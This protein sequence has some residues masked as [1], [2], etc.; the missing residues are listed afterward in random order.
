MWHSWVVI[1]EC[2]KKQVTVIIVLLSYSIIITLIFNH[3]FC[4]SNNN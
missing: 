3:Y 1:N 4:N 2:T